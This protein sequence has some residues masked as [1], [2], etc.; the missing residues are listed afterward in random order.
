M[1]RTRID[2]PKVAVYVSIIVF[3]SAVWFAIGWAIMAG[4]S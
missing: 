4:G 3:C 1:E 2:W